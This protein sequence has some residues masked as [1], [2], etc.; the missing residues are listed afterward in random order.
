MDRRQS[1]P[2]HRH[3]NHDDS[4]RRGEH[5]YPADEN[6]TTE[7]R[8]AKVGREQL[9]R[10]LEHT[11]GRVGANNSAESLPELNTRREAE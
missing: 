9:K 5:Q 2:E 7:E 11:R 10:E 8:R 3:P 6:Q 1:I 4:D